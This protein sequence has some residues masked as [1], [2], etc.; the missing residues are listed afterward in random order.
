MHKTIFHLFLLLIYL[1]YLVVHPC[2]QVVPFRLVCSFHHSRQRNPSSSAPAWPQCQLLHIRSFCL[3]F[4]TT[5]SI[6]VS[7]PEATLNPAVPAQTRPSVKCLGRREVGCRSTPHRMEAPRRGN[8]FDHQT[9]QAIDFLHQIAPSLPLSTSD[10]VGQ[11]FTSFTKTRRHL[12]HRTSNWL[13]ERAN[14]NRANWKHSPNINRTRCNDL[15][16]M[17]PCIGLDKKRTIR[18]DFIKHKQFTLQLQQKC[19]QSAGYDIF[20]LHHIEQAKQP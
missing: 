17:K 6:T 16:H 19:T 9:A 4:G 14:K 18:F 8:S 13:A 5:L 15:L 7:I 20:T 11:L 1:I 10:G 3:S 2:V 12:F